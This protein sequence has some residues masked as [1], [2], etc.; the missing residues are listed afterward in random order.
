MLAIRLNPGFGSTIDGQSQLVLNR[1]KIQ[2]QARYRQ[3]EEAQSELALIRPS[4]MTSDRSYYEYYG[5]AI[6]SQTAFSRGSLI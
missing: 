5:G 4:N 6:D 1:S 3:K 2:L